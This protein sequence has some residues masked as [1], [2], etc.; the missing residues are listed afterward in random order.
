MRR[1][2]RLTQELP[3]PD[4]NGLR[5]EVPSA[6]GRFDLRSRGKW[7]RRSWPDRQSPEATP[8]PARA[9]R[10]SLCCPAGGLELLCV[11]PMG[12]AEQ[13]QPKH[14]QIAVASRPKCPITSCHVWIYLGGSSGTHKKGKKKNYGVFGFHGLKHFGLKSV[15]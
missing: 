1:P 5:D 10:L 3:P 14:L 7:R 9:P 4:G 6:L 2:H 12:F 15:F 11:Q 13:L 8:T